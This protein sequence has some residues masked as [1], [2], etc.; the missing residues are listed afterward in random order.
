M[1][2]PPNPP[3]NLPPTPP[4]PSPA[5]PLAP[6]PY[7]P[8]PNPPK[9]GAAW[10]IVAGV[11]V[12]VIVLGLWAMLSGMPFGNKQPK[13]AS[14]QQP[15]DTIGESS[16]PASGTVSQIG[17]PAPL[18]PAPAPRTSTV[19]TTGTF[20]TTTTSMPADV[21]TAPPST[22]PQ[23]ATF[24]PAPVPVPV[25]RPAPV[26]VTRPAVQPPRPTP[27][28]VPQPSPQSRPAPPPAPAPQPASSSDG[29]L[30][31]QGAIIR[32]RSFIAQSNPYDVPARCLDISSLGFSN[33]GYTL[34]VSQGTCG[35]SAA[36]RTLDRWR[37]D[38]LTRE[39]FR[40]RSDGRFLRP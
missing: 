33:R 8:P 10:L 11:T 29:Q 34:Q 37:V 26:P 40:Q 25:T 39:V 2:P 19:D 3:S 6:P 12:L 36:A 17:E 15:L 4:N 24:A 13:T 27:Q 1:Q 31:E 18:T 23:T 30:D 21:A 32:L 14:A 22:A 35:G 28:P 20:A 16:A 38:T 7:T 9:S 5:A